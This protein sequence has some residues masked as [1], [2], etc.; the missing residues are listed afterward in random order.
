MSLRNARVRKMFGASGAQVGGGAT[1]GQP[2]NLA[3][4]AARI[5]SPLTRCVLPTPYSAVTSEAVHPSVVHVPNGWNGYE[6]W[7]AYTPYPN[8]NDQYENPCIAASN[9]RVNWVLP[10]G[11]PNPVVPNN[12]VNGHLS[13]A[14]ICIGPDNRLHMIYRWKDR[15]AGTEGFAVLSSANG[16]DWT[17]PTVVL[18]VTTANKSFLSPSMLWTGTQW[19]VYAVDPISVGRPVVRW[20]LN[21]LSDTWTTTPA[22]VTAPL[23]TGQ[24]WWHTNVKLLPGGARA[25]LAQSDVGAG[26]LYFGVS[27]DGGA[28]FAVRPIQRAGVGYQWYRSSFVVRQSPSGQPGLELWLSREGS[29]NAIDDWHIYYADGA[30]DGAEYAATR[31]STIAA[32]LA[33][34][35]AGPALLLFADTFNRADNASAIGSPQFGG[36][37]T[38]NSGTW[39]IT[40]NR[41]QLVSGAGRLSFDVGASDFEVSVSI[42]AVVSTN[43]VW[44]WGRQTDS[45]NGWRLGYKNDQ[46][47]LRLQRVQAGTTVEDIEIAATLVPGDA[48]SLAFEGPNVTAKVAGRVVATAVSTFGIAATGCGLQTYNAAVR[49]D[50]LVAWRV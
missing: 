28:T 19:E 22:V 32:L 8:T 5:A 17:T 9:D 33:S 24:A 35:S 14:D 46:P 49:F 2:R 44:L 4:S 29:I 40:G 21:S 31:R 39:G 30:F 41:L 16:S 23:G 6:Y 7:M 15:A 42:A 38:V 11:A 3:A 50:D 47:G 37:Y 20:V 48:L 34:A 26:A 45:S 1:L 27:T 13:D 12:F 43:E 18:S 10:A 25:M 36:A